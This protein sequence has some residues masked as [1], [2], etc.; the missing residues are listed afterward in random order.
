MDSGYYILPIEYTLNNKG[1][2]NTLRA[3]NTALTINLSHNISQC[4][5]QELLYEHDHGKH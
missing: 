4:F 1:A 2:A 3:I 5:L